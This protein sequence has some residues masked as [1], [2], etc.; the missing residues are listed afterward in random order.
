MQEMNDYVLVIIVFWIREPHSGCLG[1]LFHV[2]T[3]FGSIIISVV[4]FFVL[5]QRNKRLDGDVH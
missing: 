4:D 3:Y 1:S 5:L 2:C